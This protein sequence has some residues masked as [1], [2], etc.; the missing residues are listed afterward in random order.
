MSEVVKKIDFEPLSKEVVDCA[1]QIHQKMGT[2]LLENIYE[3]CFVIE[4]KKRNIQFER[5]KLVKVIYQGIEI[6]SKYKL[7]L[8]IEGQ[9]ILEL[10][11]VEK[12]T[13]A[14]QAQILTYM[15]TSQIKTG[16]LINFG[17]PF[18][19]AAIKRFVL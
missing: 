7:D 11:S 9:I 14:H 17:E 3:D 6:P 5:Q 19:K 16:L 12:I 13:A 10:K 8:V 1:Y 15:R 18:F 4:L 2:G